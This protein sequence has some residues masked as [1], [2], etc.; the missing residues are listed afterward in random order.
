MSG[1]RTIPFRS[2]TITPHIESVYVNNTRISPTN[3]DKR[4]LNLPYL[5]S[6]ASTTSVSANQGQIIS[7]YKISASGRNLYGIFPRV[8]TLG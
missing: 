3:S 6:M 2:L 5:G 1:L 8:K 7:P 4:A